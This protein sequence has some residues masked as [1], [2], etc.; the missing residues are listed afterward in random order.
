VQLPIEQ[1]KIKK[2]IRKDLGDLDPLINSLR[3]HGLMNPI[4]V[5]GK[6]ELIAGRRRL[7][8]AKILGWQDIEVRIVNEI[9]DLD[10][11]EL[12]IDENVARKDFTEEEIKAAKIRLARLSNPGPVKRMLNAMIKM[13]KRILGL[14]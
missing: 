10:R 3:R 11:L 4:V 1:I 7:E 6:N 2:R 12:E 13:I 8:S 14:Q 9:S 5:S